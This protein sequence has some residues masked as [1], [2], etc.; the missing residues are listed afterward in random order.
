MEKLFYKPEI[1]FA[2]DFIPFW[3]NGEFHLFYLKDFRDHATYGE[4][5]PWYH[6]STTD[7]I[8]YKDWG[9]AIPRG[10][11]DEPDLYIFTGSVIK[12]FGK[13]HI[14]YTAH[15]H[16]MVQKNLPMQ[17]VAHAVSDDLDKW[18]KIK[19]DSFQ[20][21]PEKYEVNDFRDPFVFYNEEMGKYCMLIVS[22]KKNCGYTAG[23]TGFYCSDDLINWTD[24]GDFWAPGMYHT[25]EC[26]DLF[27]IGD[28]W[29]MIYS[30]YSDRRMTR[31]VMSK[32][33]S[34]PWII[35]DDDYFDGKAYYAA[36]TASDGDKRYIFGWIATRSDNNDNGY[37]MWGGHLGV[38]EI[39]QRA[40]GTLA[41]KIPDSYKDIGKLE[42]EITEPVK[43]YNKSGKAEVDLFKCTSDYYKIDAEIKFDGDVKQFG[44]TFASSFETKHGYK[45]EFFRKQNKVVFSAITQAINIDGLERPV[46]LDCGESVKL[47]L[48]VQDNICVLYVG[49][50]IVL[51]SRFHNNAGDDISLFAVGGGAEIIK[52]AYYKL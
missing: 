51:S 38:Y 45:Y 46:N 43:I 13:Y 12:A 15:N 23:F 34:G 44:I 17:V 30:E 36:K 37:W 21:D 6:I 33:L 22:R 1:G 32:S 31:Y 25:H 42:A 8:N 39:I 28:C 2:A 40:D 5:T 7:F 41:C 24:L 14:F 9:E 10:T 47:T 19:Q 18:T 49:G 35:P 48:I 11:P 3:D 50:D 4:G 29:Y 20:A 27:K 26:P 52:A 16:H